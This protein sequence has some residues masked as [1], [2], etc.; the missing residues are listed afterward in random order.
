M[1]RKLINFFFF[2]FL[3]VDKGRGKNAEL[4]LFIYHSF[5]FF[6]RSVLNSRRKKFFKDFLKL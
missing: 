4:R 6:C 3:N 2:F 1:E 5:S